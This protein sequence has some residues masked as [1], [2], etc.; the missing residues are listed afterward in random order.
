MA[1]I[2]NYMQYD[3]LITSS[4]VISNAFTNA[5]TDPTLISDNIILVSEIAHIKSALGFDFYIHLKEIFSSGYAGTIT[6]AE[7]NFYDQYL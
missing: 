2:N 1:I 4:N 3:P 6:S 5:N 7:Q